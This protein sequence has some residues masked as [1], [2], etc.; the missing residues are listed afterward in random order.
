MVP[1]IEGAVAPW[2]LLVV[3]TIIVAG[4]PTHELMHMIPL[5]VFGV[6]YTVEISP[7]DRPLWIDLTTGR[8]VYIESNGPPLVEILSALAPAFLMLP[9]WYFWMQILFADRVGLSTVL[10]VGAWIVIFLPSPIDWLEVKR[11]LTLLRD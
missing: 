11:Q 1:T 3:L 7:S 2:H 4:Y 10:L 6:N 5:A 9:G 8:A